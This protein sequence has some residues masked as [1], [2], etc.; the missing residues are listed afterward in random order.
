MG[1][2]V[3]LIFKIA[4]IGIVTTLLYL[5]LKNSQKDELALM[6]SIAGVIVVVFMLIYEMSTLFETVK[7]LFGL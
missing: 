3:D 5:I 2:G 1:T 6:T 7:T 4:A